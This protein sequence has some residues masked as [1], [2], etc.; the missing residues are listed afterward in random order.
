MAIFRNYNAGARAIAPGVAQTVTWNSSDIPGTGVSAYHIDFTG[1]GN[2]FANVTRIRIKAAGQ[3]IWDL[4]PTHLQAMTQRFGRSN[5]A[6]AGADTSFILPL[7][8]ADFGDNEGMKFLGGFPRG[9]APTL[10]IDLDAA[11]AAGNAFCGWSQSDQ[12]FAFYSKSIGSQTNIAAGVVNGRVPLTQDGLI[13]GISINTV[14]LNRLKIQMS[15]VQ[16]LNLSGAQLLAYQR[17]ENTAVVVDP[18]FFPIEFPFA[19][20]GGDSYFE[21]DTQG[22]VWVGPN[23]EIT[24]HSILAN[25]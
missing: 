16:L 15:G 21:L 19:A 8:K 3:T 13:R 1:A 25:S 10:E 18:M 7:F 23:N 12:P 24:V 4:D 17:L 5:L 14:G 9:L 2:D 11:V 6:P 20:I 22:G